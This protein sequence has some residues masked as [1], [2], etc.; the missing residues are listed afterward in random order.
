MNKLLRQVLSTT[1]A[2]SLVAA[3]C[4]LSHV[5]AQEADTDSNATVIT[6]D[7]PQIYSAGSSEAGK[8]GKNLGYEGQCWFG[9]QSG[10][11]WV[12]NKN[13]NA[14]C[15][16]Y[17]ICGDGTVT[18]VHLPYD[19]DIETQGIICKGLVGE[20]IFENCQ[21]ASVYLEG[22]P[23]D[24]NGEVY[25]IAIKD[26][27]TFREAALVKLQE[28]KKTWVRVATLPDRYTGVTNQSGVYTY[29][30]PA[31]A[32]YNGKIYL[33]GG[34]DEKKKCPVKDVYA[35]DVTGNK[36][37]KSV[38]MPGARVASQAMQ[39]GKKLVVTLGGNGTKKCPKTLI[40]DGKTWSVSKADMKL[41]KLKP[42]TLKIN[43][44]LT[45]RYYSAQV[46]IMKNG[47]VY[48]G[49]NMENMGEI[50]TYQLDKDSYQ[51]TGYNENCVP[52]TGWEEHLSNKP[53][54]SCTVDDRLLIFAKMD[55][56]GVAEEELLDKAIDG[57]IQVYNMPIKSGLC[58]IQS[59]I[60]YDGWSGDAGNISNPYGC[61]TPGSKVKI[62]AEAYK[63]H[64]IKSIKINGK[65]VAV[66]NKEKTVAT[67]NHIS[68]D[69]KV[70]VAFGAYVSELN[71]RKDT[72]TMKPGSHQNL[73]VE[74]L[75]EEADNKELSY[76]SDNTKV[77]TV[78]AKGNIQISKDAKQGDSAVITVCAKDRNTV[79]KK[80]TVK[81]GE[82]VKIKKIKLS[83]EYDGMIW[84]G[85]PEKIYVACTPKEADNAN[86]KWSVSNKKYATIKDGV[87]TAK[88]AGK[89]KKV[90]VTAR[91]VDGS[92]VKTSKKFK[93]Y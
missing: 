13:P 7:T 21:K 80:C 88:K 48:T 6:S 46:S 71:V 68:R 84:V 91:T 79:V 37:S 76:E 62:R 27:R 90:V 58:S 45:T 29:H 54:V 59:E 63:D 72:F 28:K 15:N 66:K 49:A 57:D 85:K 50:F 26:N 4:P 16:L 81:V 42:D 67:I 19:D 55:V 39:V 70:K 56:E 30:S 47:L 77:A 36:W 78:D 82:P 17:V 24:V 69:V 87:I 35:Y 20:Q 1:L 34:Y 92:K 61:Y 74:I 52:H 40:F 86:V 32:A 41:L 3:A 11:T 38:K 18:K 93:I 10:K 51:D 44:Q 9:Y 23:V 31:L 33:I 60:V 2:V 22:K 73:E 43:K 89:G 14:D 12:I 64:W 83:S 65:S 75:P 25:A 5:A 8:S 53:K